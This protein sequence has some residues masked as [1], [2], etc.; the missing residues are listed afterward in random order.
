M[1]MNMVRL[2]RKSLLAAS[3]AGVLASLGMT[4]LAVSDDSEKITSA[5]AG[6]IVQ[7]AYAPAV[8]PSPGG[9]DAPS[10]K[11]GGAG[12]E[13]TH[14]DQDVTIDRDPQDPIRVETAAGDMTVTPLN[15]KPTA[16]DGQVTNGD[17]VVFA[18][19][20]KESDTVVRP[21]QDGVET[22]T[23]IRSE[24]AAEDFSWKVAL[25]GDEQLQKTKEGGVVVVD[26]TPADEATGRGLPDAVPAGT[27]RADELRT[28][29]SGEPP[30]PRPQDEDAARDAAAEPRLTT[31]PDELQAAV[32]EGQVKPQ[33]PA[34]TQ[35]P[36]S[37]Q[38]ALDAA[39][40][41]LDDSA[42]AQ[43]E[44]AFD[45]IAAAGRKA[46]EQAEVINEAHAGSGPR[47][48]AEIK[49]VWAKD[50]DG[51]DVDADLSVS[52]DTVTLHVDH[53]DESVAYP[54]VADPYI[55][56]LVPELV[57]RWRAVYRNE[58]YISGW[59]TRSVYVGSWHSAWCGI[60]RCAGLG[61]G[62]Q[63]FSSAGVGYLTYLPAPGYGPLFALYVA[64]V[65]AQRTVIDHWEPYWAWDVKLA[66]TY[67]N[68]PADSI[69]ED[70]G[71]LA[72][73]AQQ[74]DEDEGFVRYGVHPRTGCR[75]TR[76]KRGLGKK[77]LAGWISMETYFCW[78]GDRVTAG[79]SK[80]K[81]M[82]IDWWY[83]PPF[84]AVWE[85]QVE[86][87]KVDTPIRV[88]SSATA[89]VKMR[90][91]F[92]TRFCPGSKFV[93]VCHSTPYHYVTRGW[94]TGTADAYRDKL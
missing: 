94:W 39:S 61:G 64:P 22:F 90:R 43:T 76:D 78:N 51:D 4:A 55:L 91:G 79:W 1:H 17:A 7:E 48:V 35:A 80:R 20:G 31:S 27:D 21:V 36:S 59:Q 53:A 18:N 5:E 23:S 11:P 72:L 46:D 8:A 81:I 29:N 33:A 26:P 38:T 87:D 14:T 3:V 10:V 83:R 47:I 44:E 34:E 54:V 69:P 6:A 73:G 84:S 82:T 41:E 63:A 57:V 52:G 25:S 32:E 56:V 13:A 19:T 68:D 74:A 66:L 40:D 62:W 16:T 70:V 37:P 65:Y 71:E 28:H 60:V 89:G 58:T 42:A 77:G 49:P 12:F 9:N 50:A 75:T 15:V 85:I 30:D 24:E 92:R 93:P 86:P 45:D 67:V 88:G 2:R